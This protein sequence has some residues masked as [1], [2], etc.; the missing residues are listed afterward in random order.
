VAESFSSDRDDVPAFADDDV[1]R[2]FTATYLPLCRALHGAG[3][4]DPAVLARRIAASAGAEAVA[5]WTALAHAL[6]GVLRDEAA[7]AGA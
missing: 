6:A 3:A 7:K 5:P 2:L 4:I 1:V